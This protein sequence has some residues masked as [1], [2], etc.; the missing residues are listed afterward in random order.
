MAIEDINEYEW[1]YLTDQWD[2]PPGA[3]YNQ[4]YEFCYEAGWC[5]HRGTRTIKGDAA[6]EY[7]ERYKRVKDVGSS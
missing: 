1:Q 7:Y 2:G 4:T 5:D 6:V 3:A